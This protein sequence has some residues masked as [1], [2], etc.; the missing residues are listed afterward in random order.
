MGVTRGTT[1]TETGLTPDTSYEYRVSAVNGD[2][3]ES[4]QSTPV[5]AATLAQPDTVAPAAP[6]NLRVTP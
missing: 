3:V 2:G 4:A 1:L 5:Q 6:T